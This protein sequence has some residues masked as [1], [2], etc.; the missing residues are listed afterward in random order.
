M[1]LVVRIVQFHHHS[2]VGHLHTGASPKDWEW[3]GEVLDFRNHFIDTFCGH[4]KPQ[5]REVA[6]EDMWPFS[7][8]D[9]LSTKG[10]WN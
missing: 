1:W 2:F 9:A 5:A 6:G 4:Q 10:T 3:T 7:A 8:V